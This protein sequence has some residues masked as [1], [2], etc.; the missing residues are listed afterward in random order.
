MSC[1]RGH[2]LYPNLISRAASPRTDAKELSDAPIL[3]HTFS[4]PIPDR[5]S[6]ILGHYADFRIR[7]P[8]SLSQTVLLAALY[9]GFNS[10]VLIQSTE[11]GISAALNE[12]FFKLKLPGL[13]WVTLQSEPLGA[14]MSRSVRSSNKLS[15]KFGPIWLAR[16]PG[17]QNTRVPG[18]A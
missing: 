4:H 5:I 17:I 11:H 15:S 12:F 16:Y 10:L 9:C 14:A 2:A 8:R 1:L 13:L 7:I 6:H 3:R 18:V